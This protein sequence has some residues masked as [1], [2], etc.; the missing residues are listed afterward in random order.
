MRINPHCEVDWACNCPG[1]NPLRRENPIVKVGTGTQWAAVLEEHKGAKEDSISAL[2]SHLP[3]LLDC[4]CN[5]TSYCC[6]H[7]CP[8]MMNGHP[9]QEN[10]SFQ[11]ARWHKPSISALGKQ[12]HVAL[13]EFKGQ[14]GLQIEFQDNQGLSHRE[15]LS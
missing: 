8:S 12:R 14:P 4:R 15:D 2:S 6:H 3:L 13:C 5:V 10:P 11:L 9:N 1:G 7:D